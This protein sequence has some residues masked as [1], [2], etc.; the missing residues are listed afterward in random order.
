M[1]DLHIKPKQAS[2]EG[3]DMRTKHFGMLLLLLVSM[4]LSSCSGAETPA[5]EPT[6]SSQDVLNTAEAIAEATRNAV[7][8]TPSPSPIP[9][10]ATEPEETATPQPTAT[11]SG[12]YAVPNYNANIRQGP[13]ETYEVID[14]FI[15]GSRAE[16]VGRFDHATMGPW[17]FIQPIGGGRNGW[18][19]GGAV[20]VSGNA[21]LVP[22]FDPPPTS[23]PAPKTSS[24]TA[25]TADATEAESTAVPTE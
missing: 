14:F 7:T 17:W 15:E 6:M 1:N 8:S 11:P 9:P 5:A 13:D 22:Y 25:T 4:S 18:V 10:T 21:A 24:E 20:T 12:V 16:V 2:F 19:W 3:L 23:T